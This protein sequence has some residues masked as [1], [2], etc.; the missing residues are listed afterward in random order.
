[1]TEQK[2]GGWFWQHWFYPATAL[3]LATNLATVATTNAAIEP[4]LERMVL[5]DLVLVVPLFYLA[6]YCR[7]GRKGFVRCVALAC[8]GIWLAGHVVPE[9][10]HDLLRTLRWLRNACVG[11]LVAIEVA[12]VVRLYQVALSDRDSPTRTRELSQM[13]MPLWLAGIM[14]AEVAMWRRLYRWLRSLGH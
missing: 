4:W 9:Q 14:L 10:H 5:F 7:D 8:T 2:F 12:L 3:L 13:G 6:C 11:A 1:M